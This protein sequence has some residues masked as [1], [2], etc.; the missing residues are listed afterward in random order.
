M[1]TALL[2]APS[3]ADGQQCL[4]PGYLGCNRQRLGH[5]R[6]GLLVALGGAPGSSGHGNFHEEYHYQGT[7]CGQFHTENRCK[8]LQERK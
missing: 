4:S 8:N 7:C 3:A 2:M 6:C 1:V 5:Y